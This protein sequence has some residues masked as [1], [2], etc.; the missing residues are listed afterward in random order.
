[1]VKLNNVDPTN[2]IKGLQEV[3]ISVRSRRLA[4]AV[5]RHGKCSYN[6]DGHRPQSTSELAG[7]GI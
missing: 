7:A 3:T 5:L 6:F 1:M 4:E 2:Y